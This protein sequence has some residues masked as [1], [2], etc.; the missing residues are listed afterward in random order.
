[1]DPLS[2]T[3][4]TIGTLSALLH[5]TRKFI[6]FI[7]DVK[8]APEEI[9]K[10][11]DELKAFTGVLANINDFVSSGKFVSY[12][13]LLLFVKTTSLTPPSAALRYVSSRMSQTSSRH[14]T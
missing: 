10:G 3:F 6:E 4:D 12:S 7:G 1:M 13:Y 11:V 14:R 2:I 5:S 8:G 9:V